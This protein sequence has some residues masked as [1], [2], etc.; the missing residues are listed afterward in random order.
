MNMEHQSTQFTTRGFQIGRYLRTSGRK[1]ATGLCLTGSRLG[2]TRDSDCS[3]SS[4]DMSDF[5]WSVA[6][7]SSLAGYHCFAS[8]RASSGP[9]ASLF[10]EGPGQKKSILVGRKSTTYVARP[11]GCSK[12]CS[13]C[14]RGVFQSTNCYNR[15]PFTKHPSVSKKSLVRAQ[16]HEFVPT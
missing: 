5:A 4:A 9:S 2:N 15:S 13:C 14:M 3:S 10:G 7:V 6:I 12:H 1:A 11:I 16:I 8:A